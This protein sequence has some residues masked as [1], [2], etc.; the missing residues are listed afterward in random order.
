MY[1]LTSFHCA[2]CSVFTCSGFFG[3]KHYWKNIMFSG[4]SSYI[5]RIF[6]SLF[7]Q[8]YCFR[9]FWNSIRTLPIR[10]IVNFRGFKVN[11]EPKIHTS[12]SLLWIDR[13]F[14][15]I[16]VNSSEKLTLCQEINRNGRI[17]TLLS[18]IFINSYMFFHR[19]LLIWT[20]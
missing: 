1:Q 20:K 5:G 6:L 7:C 12:R 19:A 10:F 8:A 14:D 17:F 16:H 18:T 13:K 11:L 9:R 2:L 15:F 4:D 3:L